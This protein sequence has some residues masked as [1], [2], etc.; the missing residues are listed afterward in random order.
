MTWVT[1]RQEESI[2]KRP[3]H[4]VA[5]KL[6]A[7][8]TAWMVLV[9]LFSIA[10]SLA[11]AAAAARDLP[12]LHQG[13]LIFQQSTGPQSTAIRLASGSLYT[14]MGIVALTPGGPV[15]IEAADIVRET[16]LNAF[17]A[18]GARGRFAVYRVRE[19]GQARADA[20]VSAARAYLGRPYDLYFRLDPGAI[21]CS[22]LPYEAF[23]RVGIL[24][25]RIERFGDLSV[26]NRAVKVLFARR[27]ASHPECRGTVRNADAC[28]TRIQD[29]GIVTP[30]S[31]ARDAKVERVGG[32][33]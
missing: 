21:Y 10:L 28:W 11:A 16:P 9:L 8:A 27:W 20:A 30:I 15:V 23:R 26:R 29:Q 25:G 7:A 3:R 14:H 1:M 6:P 24:L 5:G 32:N 4:T 22:E 13:D 19:L 17:L 2:L 33:L 12:V 31:I 18:R